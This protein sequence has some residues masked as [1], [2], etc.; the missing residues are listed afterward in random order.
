VYLEEGGS[1]KYHFP[2]GK[3]KIRERFGMLYNQ[4]EHWFPLAS[5]C[6]K[7]ALPDLSVLIS[8][9]WRNYR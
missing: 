9:F 4:G 5:Y 6:P 7:Q 2:Q 1:V 3:K 8:L